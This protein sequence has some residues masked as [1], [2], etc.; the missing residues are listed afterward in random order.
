VSDQTA[1]ISTSFST[2]FS[3]PAKPAPASA[4]ARTKRLLEGPIFSTLL[5][6]SAPNILNLLAFTGMVTFDGFFLGKLGSDALAGASLVFPWVMLVL[7]STN[8]GMGAGVSSAV[9]R[10]IGADTPERAN[11]LVFHAFLLALV[12]GAIFAGLMLFGGPT[13]FRLMGA[14]DDMLDA[15]LIY[16]YVTLGGAAAIC[17]LNFMGNAV[18]GTG[19]MGLPAGVLVACVLAHIAISPILIFGF[20][21]LPPLGAA[22]AAWGLVLPFA[23]GGAWFVWYLHSGRALVQL[24]FRGIA[25]RWELFADILK[26]GVPGLVNIAITNLSVV[27]LTGVAGRLGRDIAIGYAMGARLEY[28]MQPIAF[29]F[30]TALVAMIGTNWGARQYRRARAIALTG[31]ATVVAVCGTIGLI[32]AI[33]PTLWLGL[34]SDDPDVFRIGGLYLH[35]VAPT[36][37]FFG[38]GLSLFYVSLGLGRG[39]A[40]AGANAVRLAVNVA[41]GLIAV[42]WLDLGMVGFFASVALGFAVYAAVLVWAVLRVKEPAAGPKAFDNRRNASWEWRR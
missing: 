31:V 24:R 5:K 25:P 23:V 41:G 12:L 16:A 38:A 34:F 9:A 40:A 27:A 6:L 35:I 7:Q 3:A 19:N 20:G 39:V 37:F 30:G 15:A 32:V 2:S 36:Y 10:A 14:Q 4:A 26:V 18:R 11:A 8:S 17:T 42:Y 21:P 33:F 13:L 22:G 1:T 29:G 28:I